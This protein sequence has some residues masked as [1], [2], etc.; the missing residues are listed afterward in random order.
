MEGGQFD[1]RQPPAPGLRKRDGKGDV[2]RQEDVAEPTAPAQGPRRQASLGGALRAR[3]R[4]VERKPVPVGGTARTQVATDGPPGPVEGAP[5]GKVPSARARRSALPDER[6]GVAREADV[7]AHEGQEKAGAEAPPREGKPLL[8]QRA[9]RSLATPV[10]PR[11]PAATTAPSQ[12]D[13]TAQ[14]SDECPSPE[15]DRDPRRPLAMRRGDEDRGPVRGAR[16][17][18]ERARRLATGPAAPSSEA[19][20]A[21]KAKTGGAFTSGSGAPIVAP[22]AVA[23]RGLT[24]IV[25]IMTFLS[26]L[27]LGG[28]ILVQRSADAWGEHVLDEVS[29]T[30]LPLDGA[31]TADRLAAAEAILRETD[32]LA[33]VEIVSERDSRALL[34]PWLG[35]GVE[36]EAL[37]V[38][39]LITARRAGPIDREAL[40][41]AFAPMEGVVLDDHRDWSATLS[42]MASGAAAGAIAMLVMMLLATAIAIVFATRSAIATNTATV[43]VLDILG[44]QERFIVRAFSRRFLAIGLRGVA[45]GAG[46]ALAIFGALHLVALFATPSP[47]ARAMFGEP[48]IGPLGFAGLVGLAVLIAALVVITSASA[49]RHHLR[50]LHP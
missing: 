41:N 42:R 11:A 43:E 18:P 40:A 22:D 36:L 33:D 46:L 48:S 17:P 16:L 35:E 5:D 1:S 32:G 21:A 47:Q 34:E 2:R 10:A 50:G 37:P 9:A 14:R 31:P 38:P 49:V 39:R 28:A 20:K 24:V 4:E 12:G 13:A 27:L 8:R 15:P 25:A 26:L 30:V 19:A 45:I 29:V 7:P 44:A 23:G 3:R 6:E